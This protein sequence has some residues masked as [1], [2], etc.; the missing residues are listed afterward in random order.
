MTFRSPRRAY[1]L[2]RP[3]WQSARVV[4]GVLAVLLVALIVVVAFRLL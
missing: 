4:G 3:W 1:R 2:P